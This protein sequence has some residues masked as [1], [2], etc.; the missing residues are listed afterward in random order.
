MHTR[1]QTLSTI[2]WSK[3]LMQLVHYFIGMKGKEKTVQTEQ[4]VKQL[5]EINPDIKQRVIKLYLARRCL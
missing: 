3:F 2:L 4:L 5:Q 1:V